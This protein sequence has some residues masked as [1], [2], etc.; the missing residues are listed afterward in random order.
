MK[1]I[2]LIVLGFGLLVVAFLLVLPDVD[3]PDAAGAEATA[4]ISIRAYSTAAAAVGTQ[5]DFVRPV[6]A[7]DDLAAFLPVV[8]F[9]RADSRASLTLLCLLRC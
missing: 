7:R 8:E 9:V 5:G 4:V 3:P 1:R 2:H 6:F